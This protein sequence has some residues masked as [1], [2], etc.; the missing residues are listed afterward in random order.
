MTMNGHRLS[1]RRCSISAHRM[2][3]VLGTWEATSL[4]AAGRTQDMS[5]TMKVTGYHEIWANGC[6][7]RNAT[8]ARLY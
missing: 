7:A 5:H 1:Q 8:C 2:H 6:E 4:R 3:I